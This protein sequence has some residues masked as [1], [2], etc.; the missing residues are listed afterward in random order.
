MIGMFEDMFAKLVELAPQLLAAIFD[1]LSA[2]FEKHGGTIMKFG[3]IY[4]GI[5][6]TKMLLTAAISS[7]KGAI[8]GKIAGLFSKSVGEVS[9]KVKPPDP[10]P[11]GEKGGFVDG[12]RDFVK[13]FKNI[14]AGDIMEAGL[15]MALLAASF[16]PAIV[17]IAAGLV[18][19]A[20]VL[21]SVPFSSLIKALIGTVGA[22]MAM[23]M[24]MEVTETIDKGSIGKAMLGAILGA[25]FLAVGMVAFA[26]A[27]G[28]VSGVV[29]AVGLGNFMKVAVAMAFTAIAALA[30]AA[31]LI[32]MSAVGTSASAIALAFL[33]AV[34]GAAFLGV[35]LFSFA[36]AIGIV[37]GAVNKVGLGNFML[38]AAAM[39][40]TAIAAF[41][42][43]ATAVALALG[44]VAF[45]LGLVGALLA[46]PFIATMGLLL[47]PALAIFQGAMSGIGFMEIGGALLGMIVIATGLL[48]SGMIMGLLHSLSAQLGLLLQ[49]FTS[50]R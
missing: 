5:I 50:L 12:L 26:L 40:F 37:A 2:V 39:V 8:I 17:V 46:V 4:L 34:L 27:I 19:T 23:K 21:G 20:M 28:L 41:A 35:A 6:F 15:K 13:G 44:I 36:I 9:K 30:L 38:V 49:Y 48:M 33:G 16:I 45:P 42:L 24:M 18:L 47:L 7:L 32:P 1:L 22:V 31:M 11:G 14:E 25:A 29:N 3:S 10:P 43:T